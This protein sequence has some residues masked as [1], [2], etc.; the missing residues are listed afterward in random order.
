M[1]SS[2]DRVRPP[3]RPTAGPSPSL[4]SFSLKSKEETT[5][6]AGWNRVKNEKTRCDGWQGKADATGGRGEPPKGE[7]ACVWFRKPPWK[8]FLR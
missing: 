3:L 1:T 8:V 5:D 7:P 2:T 4:T 6:K